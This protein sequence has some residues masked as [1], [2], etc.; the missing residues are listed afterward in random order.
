MAENVDAKIAKIDDSIRKID[1]EISQFKEMKTK[2]LAAREK[3]KCKKFNEKQKEL[4]NGDWGDG[5]FYFI[6]K[7]TATLFHLHHQNPLNGARKF[8][9]ISKVSSKSKSSEVN[10][11]RRSMRR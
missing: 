9:R 10:N 2:L 4:Q 3:L 6:V 8:V 11:S 7:F 1:A 5:E